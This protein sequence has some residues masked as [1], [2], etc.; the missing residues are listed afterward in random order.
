MESA[1]EISALC[2][3]FWL[4]AVLVPVESAVA[5]LVA[6]DCAAESAPP[7]PAALTA[8]LSAAAAAELAALSPAVSP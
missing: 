5:T 1:A 4:D 6:I 7:A 8:L 2:E 3:V